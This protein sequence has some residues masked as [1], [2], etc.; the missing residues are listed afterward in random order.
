MQNRITVLK[1]IIMGTTLEGGR[2]IGRQG[3]REGGRES[4]RGGRREA[5]R[6]LRGGQAGREGR[7]ES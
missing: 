4:R 3:I 2:D 7:M 1:I 5:G 6:E